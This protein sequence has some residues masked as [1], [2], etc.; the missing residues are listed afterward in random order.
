MAKCSSLIFPTLPHNDEWLV[1]TKLQCSGNCDRYHNLTPKIITMKN[2]SVELRQ[3]LCGKT[4]IYSGLLN[5]KAATNLILHGCHKTPKQLIRYWNG[6]LANG[7]V[8]M[9]ISWSS[10]LQNSKQN[11]LL[12]TNSL[13]KWYLLSICFV[14]LWNTW[15]FESAMV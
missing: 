1:N 3:K 11:S 6:S 12:F 13:I 15:L 9:W 2:N 7:F 8:N 14:L 5:L 10:D 4:G